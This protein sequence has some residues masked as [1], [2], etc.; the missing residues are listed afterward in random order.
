[1]ALPVRAGTKLTLTKRGARPC[2][3]GGFRHRELDFHEDGGVDRLERRIQ[4]DFAAWARDAVAIRLHP[5]AERA[6]C[7]MALVDR[8]AAHERR[9][10]F[11]TGQRAR[12][13]LAPV[14]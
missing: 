10:G 13:Q 11:D 6:E 2:W 5:D 4:E 1:M 3:S 9:Q 14:W 8:P 7:E 12:R